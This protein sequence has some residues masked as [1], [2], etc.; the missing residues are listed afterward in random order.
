MGYLKSAVVFASVAYFVYYVTR[1]TSSVVV[2]KLNATYDYIVVGAGSAGA[3][4]AARLSEDTEHTVLV[5]EA[6]GEE[7]WKPMFRIP[8]AAYFMQ[9]TEVDWQYYTEPQRN[10]HFAS[11]NGDNRSYWPKGKVLGGTSMLNTMQYVRG[12]K[13]D[14]DE[15]AEN[16]CEGWSYD[17]VLP[18]FLKSEDVQVE[19]L[20][21]TKYHRRGGPLAVSMTNATKL[22]QYFIDAGKELGYQFGDYNGDNQEVF[23]YSQT[24]VEEG[25]R[26][27]TANG[28]LRPAM[29]R[30]NLHVAVNTHVRK[31]NFANKHTVGVEIIRDGRVENLNVRK[32]VIL[33]AGSVGSPQILKLSGIGPKEHLESLGINVISDLPVG[34][35]LQD[36]LQVMIGSGIN[37]TDSI[38][39]GTGQMILSLLKY[40]IQG[41]GALSSTGI[42]GLA[43]IN[44][45]KTNALKPYPDIELMLLA[46]EPTLNEMPLDKNMT[47]GMFPE[48]YGHG[49]VITVALLHP[50]STG[51]IVLK[52]TDPLDQPAIDPAYLRE[53]ED[54]QTLIR[55]IRITEQLFE[56]KIFKNIGADIEKRKVA[57]CSSYQFRSD[58]YWECYIR[59]TAG[60]GYHPTSTCKMG[61]IH[62]QATVVDPQLRVK[63]VQGLRVVDA[64]VMPNSISG[65]TNAPTVMIAEKAADMIRNKNTVQTIKS[66]LSTLA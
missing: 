65:N 17:D 14:Y 45:E 66:Y 28:Y 3:V 25:V 52:G 30:R 5:I 10:S 32:E 46:L 55:G 59:H 29:D 15:W 13:A 27:S 2:G 41:T 61:S 7:L 6:G 51:T 21:K 23:G 8:L 57:A 20:S 26:R 11:I 49:L 34:Q 58:A 56:T 37:T 35:N 4:I 47:K 22:A 24:N 39:L 18:Y 48:D 62:D 19:Q 53:K 40:L 43:F 44:T 42:E 54:L 33:S 64:S 1:P 36:H 12:N 9:K 63:G 50:K 38:S 16:G 31:V 60:T